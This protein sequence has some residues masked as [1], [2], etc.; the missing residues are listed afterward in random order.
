MMFGGRSQ[1][2][3][4]RV[5]GSIYVKCPGQVNPETESALVGVRGQ[6][7]TADGDRVSCGGE[8]SGI[9]GDDYILSIYQKPLNY[10]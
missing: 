2:Q 5:C 6:G 1:T 8:R 7:V 3:K 4:A 10:S 9:S